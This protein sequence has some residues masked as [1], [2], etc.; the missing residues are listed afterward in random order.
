MSTD[1]MPLRVVIAPDSFKGSLSATDA[2]AA[3]AQGWLSERPQDTLTRIPLADGGEGTLDA[4]AAAVPAAIWRSAGAVTGPD[5]RPTEGRWLELPGRVAVV[6]LAQCSGLPLMSSLDPLGAS[7]VG[8]GEVIQAALDAGAQSLI[9][10]LGGSASTDGGAGALQALGLRVT[11]AADQPVARGGGALA[12]AHAID[13]STLRPP[14][15]G[16]V[17]LL[18]DVTAPLLG[19]TGAAAVFGP[20]KGA[21]AAEVRM[22]EAAL[23]RWAELLGEDPGVPG[24]GAAGGTGYG[25]LAAWR[26]V[27]R[28]GAQH[29][30]RLSGLPDALERADLLI[31]GEGSFDATSFT[32]KAVGEAL[33]LADRL[34]VATGVIA[35]RVGAGQFSAGRVVGADAGDDAAGRPGWALS[36]SDTAGSPD[37]A[38]AEPVRWLRTTA[39]VAARDHAHPAPRPLDQ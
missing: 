19:P 26:A 4:I 13:R 22:L 16:G 29:I 21:S 3:I 24:S 12:S 14:P 1:A 15:P 20:Q 25:F 11:D 17:T 31:T 33:T 34:G 9:V 35:G 39:S 6:E 8:L 5:G 7:T 10:G 32:G 27:I 18:S 2:A 36:L 28:P 23:S 30:A 38:M 37:A